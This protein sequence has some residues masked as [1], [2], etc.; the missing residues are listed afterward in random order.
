MCIK[1]NLHNTTRAQLIHI[2]A[3]R[4][5]NMTR[6]GFPRVDHPLK[7]TSWRKN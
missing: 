5:E 6:V 2:V 1:F 7:W 4:A 3:E